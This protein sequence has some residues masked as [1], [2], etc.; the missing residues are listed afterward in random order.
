MR[1]LLS[2]EF[3]K[4]LRKASQKLKRRIDERLGVFTLDPQDQLLNNHPLHGEYD[5]YRSID[6]SGDIRLVYRLVDEGVALLVRFG[7]HHELYGE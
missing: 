1:F 4:K 5:G 6:I 7:T 2:T 3:K